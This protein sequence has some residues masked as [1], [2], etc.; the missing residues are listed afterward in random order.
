MVP[1]ATAGYNALGERPGI[2]HVG[3]LAH[4]R[5]KFHDVLKAGAKKPGGTAATIVEL[6]GR[7]YGL[8]KQAREGRLAPEQI[9]AMREER[10]RPILD[11]IKALLAQRAPTTPPKSL[12]GRA[13]GYALGQWQRIEAYL[14]D[15]RLQPDNN[16]AE[17]AIRPF[18]V[19]R[20]NWLFSGSPRGA[21]ASAALYSL[22]E[23]AKANNLEPYAYL[24]H[25]F[26]RLPATRT[27]SAREALLPQYLTPSQLVVPAS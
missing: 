2:T 21:R 13:I 25:L 14:A 10:V 27:E 1:T 22:I 9:K 26:E 18:A 4:V 12:L 11:E 3:C 8:E 16:A 23:T 15:G 6:I 20:K 17:N 24:R 7:L 5:R 19:G